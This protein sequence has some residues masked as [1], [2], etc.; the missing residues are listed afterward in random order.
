MQTRGTFILEL[1]KIGTTWVV[2]CLDRN[3]PGLENLALIPGC[4][5]SAPIQNIGAYGVEFEQ[6]CDY[7][8][9]LML[10]S[11]EKRRLNVNDCKFG[12][13]DS[14]FKHEYR[15]KCAVV[16]VGLKLKKAWTPVLTYSDLTRLD[17]N[18]VTPYQVFDTVCAVRRSKLPDPNAI[19]NAGSFFKNPVVD[20]ET[21]NRLIGTFPNLPHCNQADGKVKLTAAWLIDQCQ[22]KGWKVGGAAVHDKQ[23]LVLVNIG[24]K[25]TGRDV[26]ALAKC[27]RQKVS[28][29]FSIWLECEVRIFGAD[30]ELDLV[31]LT[32]FLN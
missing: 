19:G 12:Y 10:N 22:L 24:G 31:I 1:A 21:A 29:K 18:V 23:P 8:D 16:S 30:G 6:V 13:R 3:M 5:G 11:G 7:V 32:L 9:I 4:V 17:A 28:G 27:V 15:L 2:Y 26:A 14:V 20:Y 25:A